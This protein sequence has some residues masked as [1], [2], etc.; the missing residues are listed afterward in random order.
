[1]TFKKYQKLARKTAVYP[2][3]GKSFIYPLLGLAGETGEV[4]EKFKKIFRDKNGKLDK[5]FLKMIELEIG[6]ILWYLANLCSELELS[7][8]NVAKTNIKKVFD[9]K[10]RN[11]IKGAGDLR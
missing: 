11:K 1:M 3:I 4:F 10:R 8:E 5:D 9:R 2:K 6:D 7:F